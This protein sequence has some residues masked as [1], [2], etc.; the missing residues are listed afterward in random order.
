M[1]EARHLDGKQ[2]PKPNWK[3]DHSHPP[4]P[5]ETAQNGVVRAKV[6]T[7]EY[8]RPNPR[9]HKCQRMRPCL[10]VF[11]FRRAHRRVGEECEADGKIASDYCRC[12]G[13]GDDVSHPGILPAR[14][15]SAT[16]RFRSKAA[17]QTTDVA[18]IPESRR[19]QSPRRDG[20]RSLGPWGT[21]S[22]R[23]PHEQDKAADDHWKHEHEHNGPGDHL[24]TRQQR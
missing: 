11:G 4:T 23:S 6:A 19:L 5:D 20:F 7:T 10:H 24:K 3:K 15:T 13:D 14:G 17:A 21:V 9:A 2:R 8:V 18:A 12:E 22:V 1:H 16:G